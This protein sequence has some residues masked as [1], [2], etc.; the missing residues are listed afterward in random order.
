MELVVLFVLL[1][2]L[3]VSF[4]PDW[5][6]SSWF[7]SSVSGFPVDSS[8]SSGF[9]S[10]ES[11]LSGDWS[12]SSWS[13]PG[14]WGDWFSFC[15]LS[16]LLE[17]GSWL[18]VNGASWL[19]LLGSPVSPVWIVLSFWSEVLPESRRRLKVAD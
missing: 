15:W 4:F 8:P 6:P 19:L 12:P 3:L 5:S 1:S 9:F 7:S 18:S 17:S 11:E 14:S 2:S 10:F 13:F 16:P